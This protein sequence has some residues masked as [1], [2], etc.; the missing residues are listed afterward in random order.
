M[1]DFLIDNNNSNYIK[2]ISAFEQYKNKNINNDL[3]KFYYQFNH[4]KNIYRQGWI[5]NLLGKEYIS[6]IESIADHSWSVAMLAI[7][8][9]EKYKLKYDITKCMKLSIIHE[10]GEIYAGDFTPSDNITKEKKH[11]LEEKAIKKAL[12][13]IKFENDFLELW[14]EYEKQETKEAQ[15]I[16][17]IDKLECIMQASCYGLDISYIETS[18]DNITLP[19]LKEILIELENITNDNDMPLNIKETIN[20]ELVKYI[21]NEVFPLYERNEEGHGI[22]HIKTVIER[23]VKFAKQYNA[24]LNMAYTIAAYHDIGHYIDRK[25][26]EIISAEIFMKDEKIK[27]WFTDEQ[28]NIIKEAIEDHRASSNH[29]PRSIYGMIVSTADRTIIDIDNSIKRSYSYGKR[30]YIG[31]SEEEQIY[32]VYQH[33]KEKYGENGYAKI[34]LEDKEFDESIEKLRQALSNKEQF[35]ERIKNV[36]SQ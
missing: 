10:L 12:D 29:K 20:V 9:I 19:C 31:L 36:I 1:S 21:E 15:F 34:Y 26:H 16:R 33:L 32:R 28:R 35:I 25:K 14:E 27:Q 24:D 4:L 11:E 5:K 23:S 17:Q 13:T 8:V 30:N 3:I 6:Q 22:K 7:S 2:K 18:Q